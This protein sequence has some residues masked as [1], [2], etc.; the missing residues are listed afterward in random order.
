MRTASDFKPRVA[1]VENG[2][3]IENA[4]LPLAYAGVSA[5]EQETRAREALR[6]VGLS[7]RE[8]QVLSAVAL[9]T[10]THNAVKVQESGVR[11]RP[12]TLAECAL[13]AGLPDKVVALAGRRKRKTTA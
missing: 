13:L 5:A 2:S 7:G 6:A 12:L 3:A 11:F 4:E 10:P 1:T 8:H 9:A